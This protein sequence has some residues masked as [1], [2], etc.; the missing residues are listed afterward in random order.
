MRSSPR[1]TPRHRPTS[2]RTG[3]PRLAPP[4]APRCPAPFPSPS[5]FPLGSLPPVPLNSV[6]F[7][8]QQ[9]HAMVGTCSHLAARIHV[10]L[11][12]PSPTSPVA[13]RRSS[14]CRSS[15]SSAMAAKG[16][17]LRRSVKSAAGN[18][19]HHLDPPSPSR[20]ARFQPSCAVPATGYLPCLALAQAGRPRLCFPCNEQQSLHRLPYASVDR[21]NLPR[22]PR[23]VS[24]LQGPACFPSRSGLLQICPSRH[25]RPGPQPML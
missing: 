5:L 25:H 6:L 8:V 22:G 20:L 21:F 3:T 23:V 18:D 11:N 12:L 10:V 1:A 2:Y 4:A 16:L 17:L 19:L 13:S 15:G 14:R 9:H 7:S 24:Q